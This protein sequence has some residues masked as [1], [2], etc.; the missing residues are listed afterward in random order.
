MTTKMDDIDVEKRVV[1]SDN[2]SGSLD[3]YS[4]PYM[5]EDTVEEI[6]PLHKFEKF[7]QHLKAEVRGI[8]Q[9]PM[10]EKTDTS[11]WYTAS[12]WMGGNMVLATF[13]LGALGITTF[14]LS[15]WDS[16]C[17]IIFFNLLGGMSVA[18]FSTFGPRFGLRQMVLSRYWFGYY[19]VRLIALLNCI[20]CIGWNAVNT[21]VSA[22]M[23]AIINNGALPPWA[24][25]LI[26]TLI[27]MVVSM[28]G[29]RVVHTFEMWAWI[30]VLAIFIIVAVRMAKTDAFVSEP[31]NSGPTEAAAV[32]SFGASIYGFATGWTTYG[33]DYTVYMRPDT[34]RTFVFFCI[35]AGEMFPC[36]TAMILGAACA[37]GT[38]SNAR[39]ADAYEKNSIGGLLY[40]ILVNKSLHG[41]GDFC[42]VILALSTV[43]NNIPNMYTLGL[44]A[45]T[46]WSKF[47]KVPRLVWTIIGCGVSLAIAIPAY[48]HFADAMENFMNF[49]GYWLA[50]Y[51][52]IVLPEH[53]IYIGGMSKYDISKHNDPKRLPIGFAAIFAFCCGVVGAVMGMSQVWFLGPIGKLIGD[54]TIGGDIGFELAFAFAFVG[55]NL[56]RWIELR[57]I[58]R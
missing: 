46:V 24:G 15:F 39:F 41:F 26:I 51:C 31:L 13:S 54:P 42:M 14:G 55:Y 23:L 16:V 45:Q 40:E 48:M 7:M 21:M 18:F 28:F 20:A 9:V 27:T 43:A 6:E 10:E 52:G 3:R 49:I 11:L 22:Q 47:R 17:C 4:D 1:G 2:G 30:P 57:V 25:V 34:N 8:E 32:L 29:Y 37:T 35:W 50:I 56:V 5:K 53:I 12:M 19:G 36:I 44:S 38:V 58:G 33:A